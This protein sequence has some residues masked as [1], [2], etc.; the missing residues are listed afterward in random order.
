[1]HESILPAIR[2][3]ETR[4]WWF[5]ARL[6]F[7]E[8]ITTDRVRKGARL[9][10]IGCGTGLFLERVRS[11]FDVWG[12]DP[13]PAAVAYCRERGLEQVRQGGIEQL[14]DVTPWPF[15][16]VTMWDVLEHVRFDREALTTAH[17]ALKPGGLLLLSVPAHQWL[18][19]PHDDLHHHYRRYTRSALQRLLRGAGFHIDSLAYFNSYLFPLAV[20]ER[21]VSRLLGRSAVLT[22]PP[23]I[24]NEL[25]H[26]VFTSELRRL[27]RRETNGYPI[28]LSLMA[29]AAR[30]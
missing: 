28:G 20:V 19:S 5:R 2:R 11:H 6:D 26:A 27:A 15:D 8:A 18:W 3:L 23:R 29:V 21:L 17:T 9:L 14:A 13:S 22:V 24:F 30:G 10:D 25:F 4:H 12:L 16:A 1:M 7:T